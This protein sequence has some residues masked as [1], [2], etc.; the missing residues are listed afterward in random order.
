MVMPFGLENVAATYQRLVNK[1]FKPF[2]ECT[3]EAYIDDMITKSKNPIEHT[4]HLEE[5]FGL[6][7]KYRIKLT[8]EKCVFEVGFGKF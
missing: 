6:L 3:I 5:T 8:H 2:I 1:T 4:M 7:T